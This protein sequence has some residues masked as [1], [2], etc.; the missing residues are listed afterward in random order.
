M[1]VSLL[2]LSLSDPRHP[3]HQADFTYWENTFRNI[4]SVDKVDPLTV[5]IT[6]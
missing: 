5:R 6:I 1:D 4:Q 2:D 3:F